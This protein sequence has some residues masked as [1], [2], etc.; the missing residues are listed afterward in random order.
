MRTEEVLKKIPELKKDELYFWRKSGFIQSQVVQ[1]GRAKRHEWDLEEVR[2]IQ[3]MKEL[4]ISGL[5]PK[6]AYCKA[7]EDFLGR[8]KVIA[9]GDAGCNILQ[10]LNLWNRKCIVSN[11]D[12]IRDC[13]S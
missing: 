9:I 1:D 3:L 13:C 12:I 8:I 11:N 6:E 5:S 10:R 4:C 2:K 7:I